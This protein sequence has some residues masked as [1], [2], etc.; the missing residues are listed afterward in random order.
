[1]RKVI[2][3]LTVLLL[4]MSCRNS[5]PCYEIFCENDGVCADGTCHC[6]P[7][8]EGSSCEKHVHDR[9]I[10]NWIGQFVCNGTQGTEEMK[11]GITRFNDDKTLKIRYG[12]VFGSDAFLA[13]I[14]DDY[15]AEI[16]ESLNNESYSG[17]L[18]YLGPDSIEVKFK[19]ATKDISCEFF[20][21]RI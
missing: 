12:A 16:T 6:E 18:E 3:Q 2:L 8:Y 5:E 9:F 20:L 7:F 10:G 4:A 1:M 11:F 15:N 14:N 21:A 17:V 19:E 13:T